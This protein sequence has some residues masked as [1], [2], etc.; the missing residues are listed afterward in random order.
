MEHLL[1]L[2]KVLPQQLGLLI[3]SLKDADTNTKN[4]VEEKVASLLKE[5]ELLE[6]ICSLRNE[7]DGTL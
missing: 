1:Y 2:Q 4:L 7:D 5:E 3:S 6:L